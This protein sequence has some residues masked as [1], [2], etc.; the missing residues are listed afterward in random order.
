ML[1]KY[2]LTEQASIYG[3]YHN[4]KWN[5]LVHFIFVP[6]II[7]ATLLWLSFISLPFK[8]PLPESFVTSQATTFNFAMILVV[9]SCLYYSTL[10][11]LV[12]F[13]MFLTFM[14]MCFSANKVVATYGVTD[15]IYL[16]IILQ[17]V[18]WGCQVSIGH[19]V[20][21][22]RSPALTE[23]LFQVIVSPFFLYLEF[24][25][26]FGYRGTLQKEIDRRSQEKIAK[27]KSQKK[28]T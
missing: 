26:I 13:T 5:K 20:F 19:G 23:S 7:Y 14:G 1:N 25:F 22:G 17:I 11:P 15:C 21:E 16:G 8:L 10:D 3:S 12:S 28:T 6:M 27:W 4:N 18:G 2:D 9:V 24:F